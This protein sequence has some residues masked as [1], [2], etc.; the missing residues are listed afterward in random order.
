MLHEEM[1]KGTFVSGDRILAEV[2]PDNADKLKFSKI[3]A[4]E[5]PARPSEPASVGN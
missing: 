4:F 1:L 5:P 2:D 3:P